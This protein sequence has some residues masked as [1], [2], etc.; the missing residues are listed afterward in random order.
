MAP[1]RSDS[2]TAKPHSQAIDL[3][4]QQSKATD[5]NQRLPTWQKVTA[6]VSATAT[7]HAIRMAGTPTARPDKEKSAL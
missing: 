4:K 6:A 5:Q 2:S 3:Y 7:K 1:Q